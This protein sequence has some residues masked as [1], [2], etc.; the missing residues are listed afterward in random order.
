M[1]GHWHIKEGQQHL[2]VTWPDHCIDHDGPS[3]VYADN[4]PEDMFQLT[5]RNYADIVTV[6]QEMLLNAQMGLIQHLEISFAANVG[7]FEQLLN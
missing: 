1:T 4:Q 5:G 2:N 7:N 6:T 3:V